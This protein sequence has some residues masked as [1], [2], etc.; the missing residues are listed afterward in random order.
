MFLKEGTMLRLFAVSL[1]LAVTIAAP[2]WAAK[3]VV[4]CTFGGKALHGKVQIVNSFPDI[5]VQEVQSFP[6]LKVQR[7]KSFPDACGQWQFVTSFPD[8]TIQYVQSF[9][10]LKIQFV[11]SFPGEP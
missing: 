9:P 4:N 6:D 5:K 11:E 7:V 2:G 10:D 1:A 8:F 3:P